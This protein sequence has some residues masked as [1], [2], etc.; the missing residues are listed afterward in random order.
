MVEAAIDYARERGQDRILV[1]AEE[2]SV[3]FYER[4]GF[5]ITEEWLSVYLPKRQSKVIAT[6]IEKEEALSEIMRNRND[7]ILGKFHGTRTILFEFVT[8]YATLRK[9]DIHH[10]FLKTQIDSL[11]AIIGIRTSR[12]IPN[13][14]WV[15]SEHGADINKTVERVAGIIYRL[16]IPKIL[17]AIPKQNIDLE[18]IEKITWMEKTI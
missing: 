8:R 3:G 13:V 17:T 10:I 16:N 15:W 2:Q 14:A 6:A 9:L 5:R 4:L 7:P 12:D 11:P 1:A 18:I